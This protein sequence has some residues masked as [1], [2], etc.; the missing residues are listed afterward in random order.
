MAVDRVTGDYLVAD[1]LDDLLVAMTRGPRT[2]TA[3]DMLIFR[4]GQR[5]AVEL[6]RRR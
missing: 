2:T 1:N 5:A 4:L 3:G 6:R